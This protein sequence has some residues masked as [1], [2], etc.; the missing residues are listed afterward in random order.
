[1]IEADVICLLDIFAHRFPSG[2]LC[3]LRLFVRS[4]GM[5]IHTS[6]VLICQRP[7]H[8]LQLKPHS[9][10][11]HSCE[12]ANRF[13]ASV[14]LLYSVH[15]TGEAR[16]LPSG[17]E[18]PCGFCLAVSRRSRGHFG[19]QSTQPGM[20]ACSYLAPRSGGFCLERRPSCLLSWRSR[21]PLLA[22]AVPTVALSASQRL[23]HSRQSH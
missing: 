11:L 13:S 10:G 3:A 15:L 22:L 19:D 2:S 6:L 18:G 5:S 14:L 4:S 9:F 23:L 12:P 20:H 17:A 8:F 16:L 21:R 1:M 7:R